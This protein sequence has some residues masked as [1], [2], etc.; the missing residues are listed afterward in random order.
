MAVVHAREMR[1]PKDLGLLDV[2]LEVV[3]VV[4]EED[5]VG[6]L[7]EFRAFVDL[8]GEEDLL[9]DLVPLVLEGEEEI[10]Q[11]LAQGGD[12]ALLNRALRVPALA[13][14]I[15]PGRVQREG[16]ARCRD[17]RVGAGRIVVPLQVARVDEVPVDV[18]LAPDAAEPVV[19]HEQA[20]VR[21]RQL[22]DDA[23]RHRVG[24]GVEVHGAGV[25]GV[26]LVLDGVPLEVLEAVGARDD[27]H[28]EVP[29]LLL[30]EVV[31]GLLARGEGLGEV[32][33]EVVGIGALARV[34]IDAVAHAL[35]RG[36]DRGRV[37][38]LLQVYG[39][40]ARD[41]H[42]LVGPGGVGAGQVDHHRALPLPAELVPDRFSL[43][44][45]V[46]GKVHLVGSRLQVHEAVDPVPGGVH[47]GHEGGPAHGGDL[48][49][50]RIHLLEVGRPRRRD[51]GQVG[52]DPLG[53]ELLQ[54]GERDAVQADEDG[55]GGALRKEFSK[56]S[57][58]ASGLDRD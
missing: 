24:L 25:V 57:H 8:L 34:H 41:E 5:Q 7:V 21:V 28:E 47:A 20:E 36:Q 6:G 23:A 18:D 45:R 33:V 15:D 31:E 29:V 19:A 27:G 53:D 13:V 50:G 10:P 39:H 52:G 35:E 14:H 37:D 22:L 44:V 17:V 58:R 11:F 30:P 56:K 40:E 49:Q 46:A 43:Q 42:A 26:A 54:Q 12:I 38:R 48:G 4:G 51:F 3:P 9:D 32:P 2:A 16:A 55:A 1:A